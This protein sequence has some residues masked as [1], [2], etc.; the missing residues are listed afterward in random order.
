MDSVKSKMNNLIDSMKEQ[1]FEMGDV[2]YDHPEIGLQ[3]QAIGRL[4]GKSWFSCG[5]RTGKHAN[6]I[7]GCI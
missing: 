4:V 2:I 6:G 5:K 3:E 7:S 1:L